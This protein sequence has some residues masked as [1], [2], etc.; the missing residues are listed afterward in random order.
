MFARTRCL[1]CLSALV[2][3]PGCLGDGASTHP[4]AHRGP[5]PP[6]DWPAARSQATPAP[7]AVQAQGPD[8]AQGAS[9]KPQ[10]TRFSV[11]TFNA[12]WAF[13]EVDDRS[14]VA[15]A[16]NSPSEIDWNWKVERIGDL[17]I[18]KDLDIVALQSLG[19]RREIVDIAHYVLSHGG[20]NY[21]IAYVEGTDRLTGQQVAVLSKFLIHDAR[22][23]DIQ[24][25]KHLVADVMLPD[26]TQL[27]VVNAQLRA[28]RYGSQ[29]EFRRQ[30]ARRLRSE[31]T[32]LRGSGPVLV[33]GDIGSHVLPE[34]DGYTSSAP[35]MF[36]YADTKSHDDDCY[37]SGESHLAQRTHTNGDTPGRMFFCGLMPDPAAFS[38][39]G[40]TVIVRGEIDD[41]RQNPWTIPVSQR[42][43]SSHYLLAAEIPLRTAAAPGTPAAR[44]TPS[45]AGPV[46]GPNAAR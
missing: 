41:R 38:V 42:D 40:K 45:A 37:D 5:M 44:R 32:K 21:D 16:R 1:L 17:L 13:D 29:T 30:E 39:V 25:S 26:Y 14:K 46:A 18:A 3:L 20:P 6:E 24:V 8:A 2:S 9:E 33:L 36:A 11:G 31:I 10:K 22:R 7:D 27:V 23:L 12:D 4:T 19:G 43:T 34:T 35:G 28:G 15:N